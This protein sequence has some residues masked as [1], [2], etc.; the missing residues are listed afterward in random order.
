MHSVKTWDPISAAAESM[1]TNIAT[2]IGDGVQ[3]TMVSLNTFWM[4]IGKNPIAPAETV[5]PVTSDGFTYTY[6]GNTA[7]NLL[8]GTTVSGEIPS[9]VK[10]M[11]WG[12]YFALII[13]I[14]AIIAL[15]IKIALNHRNG[16][17]LLA[18]GRIGIILLGAI[19]LGIAAALITKIVPTGVTTGNSTVSLLRNSTSWLTIAIGIFSVIVG[20][21]HI[22]LSQKAEGF[23][24]LGK[25][26]LRLLIVATLSLSIISTLS[27][28]G[29]EFSEKI[30]S[31]A[32]DC[33]SG[34][35]SCFGDKIGVMLMLHQTNSIA[36]MIMI[37][38]GLLAILASLV[39]L[40][41]LIFRN[42][43][44]VILAG[45]LPLT[46]AATNTELGKDIWRK[47]IGWIAAFL[48]FKPAAAIV[49]AAAF[50]MLNP[51]DY[52]N[53]Q[54][55]S[56]MQGLTLLILAPL[57][58]PAMMKLFAP[59]GMSSGGSAMTAIGGLAVGAGV[60][61]ATGGAAAPAMAA[62]AQM[63]AQV[64]ASAENTVGGQS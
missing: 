7:A 33:D 18:L 43:A 6:G 42:A 54:I 56:M 35:Q 5:G 62:G 28:A 20:S 15:G 16:E 61:A 57:M 29:D 46:A 31:Y 12:F 59:G 8:N 63:G 22:F 13:A 39:Q 51:A 27:V 40:M 11:N 44:L 25:S 55:I 60:A 10:I 1:L 64:G 37:I 49:Y 30:I 53:D 23:V 58:M 50:S 14:V 26:L 38:G 52:D 32:A 24:D 34:T 36:I 3:A 48:A 21:I 19:I 47:A 45:V 4:K 2:S 41:I 9:L 17:P